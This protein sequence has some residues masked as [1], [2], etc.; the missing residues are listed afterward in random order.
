MDTRRT[1]DILKRFISGVML[2]I[3]GILPGL[4]GSVLAVAFGIYEKLLDAVATLFK[5]PKE[6]IGFLLPIG[7]GAGA[8]LYGVALILDQVMKKYETVLIFL[9]IG[10]IIGSMPAIV[11]EAKKAAEASNRRRCIVVAACALAASL[12]LLAVNQGPAGEAAAR[13]QPL[14]A[15]ATG[16]ILTVGSILPGLSTSVVLFHLGW[17]APMMAAF[18]G[19]D[20]GVLL[21]FVLG[22]LT[23]AITLVW[24]IRKLLKRWPGEM[25][26]MVVGLMIGSVIASVPRVPLSWAWLYYAAAVA[27]GAGIARLMDR[28]G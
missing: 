8:G 20:M 2:G 18:T 9:F 4:S 24:L 14:Q 3:G 1:K 10:L 27:I 11:R 28:F 15:Y 7:A 17:Y 5:K 22:A 12:L 21:W 13:M 25:Y 23:A 26:S 16:L 19:M 6:N